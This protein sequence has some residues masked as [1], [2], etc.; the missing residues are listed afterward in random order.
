MF[1]I[2][3]TLTE[4]GFSFDLWCMGPKL[5][6]LNLNL[7]LDSLRFRSGLRPGSAREFDGILWLD[8]IDRHRL[9]V[10]AAQ[11]VSCEDRQ[12]PQLTLILRPVEDRHIV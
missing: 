5:V 12:E 8:F 4:P 9:T 11:G 3:R 10:R 6:I 2:D 1:F 7:Q